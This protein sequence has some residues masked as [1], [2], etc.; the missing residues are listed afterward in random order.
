MVQKIKLWLLAAGI[1]LTAA[2][3]GRKGVHMPSKE[4]EN[5]Q[6]EPDQSTKA[7]VQQESVERGS[8]PGMA[9]LSEAPSMEIVY[10]PENQ[11]PDNSESFCKILPGSYNWH[12]YDKKGNMGLALKG[13]NLLSHSEQAEKISAAAFLLSWPVMPDGIAMRQYSLEIPPGNEQE[14][15]EEKAY[16]DIFQVEFKSDKLYVITA[17]WKRER[18]KERGFY[19]DASYVIITE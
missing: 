14:P 12:S 10:G 16:E 13:T 19:G 1:L 9:V 11:I 6:E 5:G 2:A 8:F 4:Y 18:L 3:C 17:E 15:E 7:H